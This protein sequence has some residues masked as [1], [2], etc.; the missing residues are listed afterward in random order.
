MKILSEKV[1]LIDTLNFEM[2]L[3]ICSLNDQIGKY[4]CACQNQDFCSSNKLLNY[5]IIDKE[6]DLS[7]QLSFDILC[8]FLC[9]IQPMQ[10][11]ADWKKL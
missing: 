2:Y 5:Y 11:Y 7:F 3:P 10:N 1:V 9:F 8:M 6:C 4:T